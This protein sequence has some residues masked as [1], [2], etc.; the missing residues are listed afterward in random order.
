MDKSPAQLTEMEAFYLLNHERFVTIPAGGKG[1]SIGKTTPLA[2]NKEACNIQQPA[3]EVYSVGTYRSPLTNEIYSWHFNSN[4]IHY[5]LRISNDGCEIVYHGCLQLSADPKHSIE[6]WKAFLRVEKLCSNRHGKYLEWTNGKHEIGWL[7]VEASIATNFFTTP[8]FDRCAD[9]CAM[10]SLCVPKPCGCLEGE[11]VPLPDTERG[12][13]NHLVDA[14]FM[15]MF[16]HVYYDGRASEWSDT[17]TLFYQDSKGCFDTTAGFSRCLRLRVPVGNPMVDKIEIASSTDGGASWELVDTI[18]KYKKYNSAQQYWYERELSESVSGGNYSDSDCSFDY[19]FCNDK[20]CE[21]ISP[22]ETKRVY[23]PIPREAQG[24]IPIKESVGF[25]NY[26]SG[27]CVLDKFEVD[28]VSVKVNCGVAVDCQIE[29]A[30]VKVRAI[31]HNIF[32]DRNQFIYQEEDGAVSSTTTKWFGGL[33]KA[34]DGGME[35]GFDQRFNGKVQNFIAYIEGTDY[36]TEMTQWKS[37]AFFNNLE[38]W[39]TVVDLG[40]NSTKRRLRRAARSGE[41]FYQEA[42]FKVPK[43]TKGFIRLASHHATDNSTDTSTFVGGIIDSITQYKGDGISSYIKDEEI[44]FDT[45]LGD[46]DIK[47]AFLIIDNA[48]DGGFSKVASAFFGYVKDKNNNP[49]EGAMVAIGSGISYT[50]YNGFYH[51]Y[52]AHGTNDDLAA[53]VSVENTA[54]GSWQTIHTFSVQAESGANVETNITIENQDYADGFYAT[55]KVK[56]AD[57]NGTAIGGVRVALSGSKYRTTADDGFATFRIRN[58]E[59]RSRYVKAVLMDYN[60]CFDVDCL[61]NCNPCI[62]A[63]YE[64]T[65]VSYI[66]KPTIYLPEIKINIESSLSN[67]RGLKAGGNYPFAFVLEG[68]GRITPAN[69]I[70]YVKIP[71][72]QEKGHVGFCGLSFDATGFLA[73]EWATC[74]KI[75]RGVNLNP[76]ELQWLVDKVERIGGKIRLTIQSLN[77]YNASYFFKTNTVYQFL[78]GD[79]IEFISNGDGKIFKSSVNGILNYQCLSP[80]VDKDLA[81][82]EELPADFFNQLLIEDDGKLSDLKEGALIEL[83]R[84]KE[85]TSEPAYN[86]ICMSIP[87]ENRR[88]VVEKGN[89]NSFDTYLI[90]R[91]IGKFAVTAFEHHSPSDFWGDKLTDAALNKAHFANKYENEK[92]YGRNL[93]VS[94]ATQPNWFGDIIKTFDA[95]E[96]GDIV[97]MNIT[98]GKVILAI[99]EHDNFLAQAADDLLRVGGDGIIRASTGDAII[100]DS[101]PKLSGKFGCQYSSAGSILFGDG[102]ATWWDVNNNAWVNHDYNEAK[103]VSFGRVKSW[104]SRRCQ[105]IG[106]HNSIQVDFLN[107]YRFITGLNKANGTQFLTIKTLREDGVNN[108]KKPYQKKNETMMYHPVADE[109]F[110][111]ASFT[112]ESYSQIDLFDQE[113]CAFVTF[114]KGKPYIHPIIASKFDEFFGITVDRVVGLAIN[115]F[116][117]KNKVALAAEVQGSMMWF[118]TDV[119]TDKAGFRSEIPPIKWKGSEGKWNAAFLCNINS[120]GGLH[121]NVANHAGEPPRGRSI[122][123]TFVRDNTDALKYNTVDIAKRVKYDELEGFLFKFVVSEQSGFSGNL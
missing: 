23:N 45:C 75:V 104:V 30:T 21:P 76:F 55:I 113:G 7:D 110:G 42:E 19:Y 48:V 11:F 67:S 12:L 109:F 78:K 38:K 59:T 71:K 95:P 39:G 25:Y 108:E 64:P 49:V 29:Y 115:K 118:V 90:K 98:D 58:Y 106:F 79:R 105:E 68:C 62:I 111:F 91:K 61:G 116:P 6:Q 43:G 52:I 47:R 102:Y 50:D 77:D 84:A 74:L 93:S 87:I 4:G 72:S 94:A 1:N 35:V 83:Q 3:G 44:Y 31:I 112:P 36:W 121:G 40:D 24:L 120:R 54:T 27:N 56:V 60:N 9:P 69:E 41:F 117:E 32:H 18:E 26:K 33:N 97:A 20:K 17:S 16:R 2:A 53:S 63:P 37:Y 92:R 114:L 119:T 46:Q 122:S 70:G 57:C 10:I 82:D 22:D 14:G 100:S 51:T 8:F 86:E 65:A 103:D 28:K 88:L 66:N 5:I 81:G 107:H 73:P 85:C 89:F 123:V 15:F 34:L 99:G 101:Q 13:S 80:F 96:H